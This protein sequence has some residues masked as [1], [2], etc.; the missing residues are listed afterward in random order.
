MA[1]KPQLPRALR[2]ELGVE[3]T[4]KSTK[5]RQQKRAQE[6]PRKK[7]KLYQPQS[8]DEE[9]ALLPKRSGQKKT[10]PVAKAHDD[11]LIDK[12]DAEIDYWEAKLGQKKGSNAEDFEDGLDDIFDGLDLPRGQSRLIEEGQ[13]ASGSDDSD[14]D[15]DEDEPTSSHLKNQAQ[16]IATTDTVDAESFTGFDSEEDV[17]TRNAA[18]SKS[19]NRPSI[20]LPFTTT[21]SSS[22]STAAVPTKYVPPALR[23]RDQSTSNTDIRRQLNGLLNRLSAA[24]ISSIVNELIAIYRTSPRASINEELT[25]ILLHIVSDKSGLLESFVILHAALVAALYKCYGIDFAASFVQRTVESILA[26]TDTTKDRKAINLMTLVT[27]LYNYG[28]I[29]STLLYDFIR[30]LLSDLT[31]VNVEILLVI[32]RSSGSQMRSDDPTS[33]KEILILLQSEMAR[34][35]TAQGV[36]IPLRI[37]FMVDTMMNLKNN[38]VTNAEGQ[39][40]K[41]LRIRMKRYI[42]GLSNQ[43]GQATSEPLRVSLQDIKNVHTK[44]KWWLIGASWR[45]TR[46][47]GEDGQDDDADRH[48]VQETGF[49][50]DAHSED[51]LALARKHRLNNPIRK[52]IFITILSASDYLEAVTSVLSLRLKKSQESEIARVLLL[53]VAAEERYNPYYTHVAKGL[54]ERH[55]MRISLQFCLWDFLRSLGET[56]IGQIGAYTQDDDDDGDGTGPGRSNDRPSMRKIVNV[57]KFY[58]TLVA[59]SVLPITVLKTL[60]FARLQ[61]QTKT[62]LDIFF[63]QLFLHVV[64]ISASSSSHVKAST[65]GIGPSSSISSATVAAREARQREVDG[66]YAEI[67]GKIKTFDGTTASQH[68]G[69][70]VSGGPKLKD[71]IDWFLRRVVA[72]ACAAASDADAAIVKEGVETSRTILSL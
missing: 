31:E 60:T 57:A 15:A 37:K 2:S 42:G 51:L 11:V 62:F 17:N 45:N 19:N 39:Q 64:A 71:G 36:E 44:G 66:K 54:G 27:E 70:N 21:E 67:F 48:D 56:E 50:N 10:K 33:L 3:S 22:P 58:G 8:D 4:R 61:P 5:Q 46:Q 12:D 7:R 59:M 41:E 63:T 55:G 40:A 49:D 18:S 72:K 32:V 28:V 34:Q 13:D 68:G 35:Y 65:I 38:K 47:T 24:N 43:V 16:P 30:S 9:P 29:A 6:E 52:Q 14:A 26:M 25:D 69:A 20:Y 53:L 1:V 23:K